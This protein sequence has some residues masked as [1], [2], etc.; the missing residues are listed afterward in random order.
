MRI[1]IVD[2]LPEGGAKR[3]VFQQIKQL[4]KNHQINYYTNQTKSIFPFAKY[5]DQMKIYDLSITTNQWLARP[6]IEFFSFLKLRNTYQKIATEINDSDIDIVVLHHCQQTQAPW[7]S[8]FLKKP[9]LY[10][11]EETLRVY[12]EPKLHPMDHIPVLKRW[13]EHLRRQL[14]AQIDK[15]NLLA[16]TKLM[17][18]S[19]YV[20]S[21]VKRCY[22]RAVSVNYLGVNGKIFHSSF[23]SYLK[24]QFLFIG[25]KEDINGYPLLE[26]A[27]ELLSCKVEIKY[28]TF[29]N[30]KFRLSDSQLVK[31]Y[32]SS[33]ATLCL[34]HHEPFGL[35]ALESMAC[36]TPVIAIKEGGYKETVIHKQ[37]G[38]LIGRNPQQLADAM[39]LIV[40][41]KKL[42]NQ[43]AKKGMLRMK[44]YFT[45]ERHGEQLEKVLFFLGHN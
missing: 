5:T 34:S 38:L 22:Q 20:K 27:L 10:F 16:T 3:V 41:D 18:S 36:G 33:V 4:S 42:R 37:T 40:N 39:E 11:I 23:K 24:S 44:Q 13:Y 12:Y 9:S 28:V 26:R 30:S 15:R 1:A 19:N 43:L 21:E 35:I 2:N 6:L 31:L 8:K 17:T 45:W 7:I 25:E 29:K 32:Q 14:I